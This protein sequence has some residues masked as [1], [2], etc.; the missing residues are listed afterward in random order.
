MVTPPDR[1]PARWTIGRRDGILLSENS[2][3]K[4]VGGSPCREATRNQK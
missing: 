1:R 4:G 3:K 2:K